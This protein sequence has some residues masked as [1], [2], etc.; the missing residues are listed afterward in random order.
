M[1]ESLVH[2]QKY[3]KS[4]QKC[5]IFLNGSSFNLFE[6]SEKNGLTLDI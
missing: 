4:E 3:N 1:R 6:L 5:E 2:K